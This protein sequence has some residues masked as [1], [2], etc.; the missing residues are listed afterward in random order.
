MELEHLYGDRVVILND[1][2]INSILTPFSTEKVEQPHFT[3]QLK[4]IYSHLCA[5]ALS[6]E[7]KTEKVKVAT[8]MSE[9]HPDCPLESEIFDRN[10]KAVCVD[11]A[12]AGMIPSQVCY[13]TLNQLLPP[14]N[15]RQ[16]HVWAARKV[17]EKKEVIGT[18]L[19]GSKIG[20]PV[21]E[22]TVLFPD[23][24][25]ATGGT[26]KSVIEYYK[27]NVDGP[28]KKYLG[29]H[30]IITPEFLKRVLE[31]P[32]LKIYACRLD[33][34]LS[35]PEILRSVPGTHWDK[36]RGINK[37]SYIVPGAGGVG[38]LLNNSYV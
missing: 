14:V 8:R 36:E 7:L 25:G 18:T 31:I 3:E 16:D 37:N 21:T 1:P 2:F 35:S 33:R 32:D 29:L 23:P 24:M 27:E 38:E 4:K 20:G 19:D 11:L 6:R 5:F 13:E 22:S 12:R 34:G 17:N 10:Q 9:L 30:I 15:V 26:L 28:A